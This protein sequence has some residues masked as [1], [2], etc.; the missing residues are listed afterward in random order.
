MNYLNDNFTTLEQGIEELKK[1]VSLRDKMGGSLYWNT[2]NDDCCELANK[3]KE[4]GGNVT[5]ISKILGEGTHT[6]PL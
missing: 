1:G 5:E 6:A 2:I 3:I 4:L